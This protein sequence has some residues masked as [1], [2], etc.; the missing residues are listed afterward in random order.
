MTGHLLGAAGALEA[1]LAIMAIEQGMLPPTINQTSPDPDCDLDYVPN[2]AR[3]AAIKHVMSN[4]MGFGGHNV[5]LIFSAPRT[6]T[7]PTERA[8]CRR[9]TGGSHRAACGLLEIPA[10]LPAVARMT[11]LA[12]RFGFDLADPLAGDA[13]LAADL[14]ECAEST[15]LE[16]EAKHDDLAL[17][18]R[19]LAQRFA[20][21][22]F[23]QLV[24]GELQSGAASSRLR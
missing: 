1:A 15:V 12:K 3:R 17:A 13:E 4:S 18:L 2:V 7:T 5:S 24:R 14:F 19:E 10:Q 8:C 23:Q 20:N 21:L 6:M 16:P 11:Q 9:A 22:R